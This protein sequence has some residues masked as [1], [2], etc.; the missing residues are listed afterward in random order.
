MSS[1]GDFAIWEPWLRQLRPG[2]TDSPFRAGHVSGHISLRGD[3]GWSMPPDWGMR[4]YPGAADRVRSALADAGM[5][6]IS[7]A[8]DI[9]AGGRAVL[10]L[11]SL[12]P[13]VEFIPA[14]IGLGPLLLVEG[15]VPEPWRRLPEPVRARPA[16]SVD[17]RLLERALRERLPVTTGASEAEIA[18]AE[19]RLD[20]PLPEELK[21]LYRVTRARTE[22][23]DRDPAVTE[24]VRKTVG[25]YLYPLDEIYLATAIA[26]RRGW[27]AAATEA[28]VT[29]PG[30]AVQGLAG[31]P[32]WIVFGHSDGDEFAV[33]LTPGPRGHTGQVIMLRREDC[34][35]AELLHACLTDRV[36]KKRRKPRAPRAP[37]LPV[38]A[39]VNA[40]ALHSIEAAAHSDLEVL[41]IGAWEG[42]PFSLAAVIGLPRLRTLTALPATL[43][44]P[45]EVASLTELEYLELG[46]DGW[47]ALLDARAVPRGLS[48]AFIEERSYHPIRAVAIANELLTLWS[49]PPITQTIV[50]GHLRH[51]AGSP[52]Q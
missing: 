29:P 21:V 50:E 19:A 14:G 37:E 28:A 40:G 20:I 33:D 16:R 35:G 10:Y 47:Q 49:R 45:L 3:F 31:S 5:D 11:L 24:H 6:R 18:A 43:A 48:A 42:D 13:A 38:V 9:F 8:A 39:R 30:A 32:G 26:R 25:C 36:M 51:L 7:F 27:R 15:A 22:D 17:L 52:G 2:I 23:W 41:S 4:Y 1:I 44:D 46:P 34:I 12:G